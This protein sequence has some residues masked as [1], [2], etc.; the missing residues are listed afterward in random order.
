MHLSKQVVYIRLGWE[1]LHEK[2]NVVLYAPV[3]RSLREATT[4]FFDGTL[5]I[6]YKH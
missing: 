2:I 6:P 4:L 1:S 3:L 5:R